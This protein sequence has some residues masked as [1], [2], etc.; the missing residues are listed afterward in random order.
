MG[1]YLLVTRCSITLEPRVW[2]LWGDMQTHAWSELEQW[3]HWY[4]LLHYASP[5]EEYVE[6]QIP[7]EE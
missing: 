5:A 4:F 6:E 1:N 7:K 2:Q 3:L